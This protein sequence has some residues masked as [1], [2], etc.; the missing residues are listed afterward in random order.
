MK[1]K[2][3]GEIERREILKAGEEAYSKF[4]DII[5]PYWR[6]DPNCRETPKRVVKMFVNELFAGLNNDPPKITTFENNGEYL[7]IVFQGDIE[8]KSICSHHFLPFFG[9]A[10]V[11]Y[12]PK[13]NGMIV[14]LSKLNRIVDFFARRPQ[15][16]E[17]LTTQI[18]DAIDD[19]VGYD[20]N[21][22]VAVLIEATHTCVSH[23][24]IGQNSIMKTAKLSGAF[25]EKSDTAK[26]E[27]YNFVRDLKR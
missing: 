11:A 27:F 26:E 22:G 23:R 12:I 2:P 10:Y 9:R 13:K 6:E 20:N 1:N 7:G 25:L 3:L 17:A 14:G 8:V 16:Q 15:V 24:G 18:H 5:L 19:L 21:L 4:M